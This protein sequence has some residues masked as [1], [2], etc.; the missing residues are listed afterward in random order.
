[1]RIVNPTY[2]GGS[3]SGIT[4]ARWQAILAA[5]QNFINNHPEIAYFDADQVQKLVP[6]LADQNTFQQFLRALNLS[7]VG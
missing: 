3:P 2:T 4:P 1:M 5:A 6:E 7:I